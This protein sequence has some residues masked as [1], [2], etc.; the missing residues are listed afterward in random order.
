MCQLRV[1]HMHGA[2]TVMLSCLTLASAISPTLLLH[3]GAPLRVAFGSC[4]KQLKPQPVWDAVAA[5]SPALWLWLG[6]AMYPKGSVT[7]AAQLRE[8][9]AQA[10]EPALRG[11]PVDGVYDD[12]DYG[13]ND[14][15]VGWELKEDARQLFLDEVVG[16]PADSAR[17]TQ[18]GGLYGSRTLGEPPR[19]LKVVM[20]RHTGITARADSFILN[21]GGDA[22]H[23]LRPSGPRGPV[24]WRLVARAK[25]GHDTST[26]R[27]T[28]DTSA[29]R[30]RHVRDTSATR[31]RQA[32]YLAGVTRSACALL[33]VGIRSPPAPVLGE[34]VRGSPSRRPE[35]GRDLGS[36]HSAPVLD[37]EQWAWLRTQLTNSTASAHLIVSS[38]Q[39]RP[40][41]SPYLPLSPPISSTSSARRSRRSLLE[42]SEPCLDPS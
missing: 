31:P 42:P 8:A 26:T 5:Q 1:G 30:P 21:Q 25:G 14:G 34:F 29:T 32:G 9:Y 12:H 15:G 13:L 6:D 20:L 33:G 19:Q 23:A 24:T 37:E 41:I 22:R 27:H 4:R 10:G 36:S 7:S 40:L 16:A 38:V 3:V 11:V 17:R 39:A 2:G 28:H 18:R 35:I